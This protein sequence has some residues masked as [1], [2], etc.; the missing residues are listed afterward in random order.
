MSKIK[1][2]NKNEPTTKKT[3]ESVLCDN[4]GLSLT[5]MPSNLDNARRG[6]NALNV[7]RDLMAAS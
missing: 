1:H 3:S 6:L 2:G 4:L 7:L 5:L